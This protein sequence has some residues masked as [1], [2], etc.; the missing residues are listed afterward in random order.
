[1]W[2]N[3]VIHDPFI[4]VVYLYVEEIEE[5]IASRVRE[6]ESIVEFRGSHHSCPTHERHDNLKEPATNLLGRRPVNI[7]NS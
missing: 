2:S 1:M 7:L 6:V 4:N 3:N 5:I